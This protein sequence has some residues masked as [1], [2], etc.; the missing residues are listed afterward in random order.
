[1]RIDNYLVFINK[2]SSR[3]KAKEAVERGEVFVNGKT[4]KPSFEVCDD[5]NIT[6]LDKAG[7]FVSN[8]A[9]KLE[10]AFDVFPGFNVEDKIC[11]DIGASTGGFTQSLLL[12][13]AKRVFAVDV[14]QSLLNEALAND[15]RVIV[16]DNTNARYIKRNDFCDCIDRIV[17]DVSFIS[18]T[19]IL[20]SAYSVLS[21]GGEAVLL[22]KPQFECGPKYL[23]KNGI[24]VDK[25][26]RCEACLKISR[27]AIDIGFGVFGFNVA[28]IKKDKNTEFLIY[29][30]KSE[31]GHVSLDDIATFVNSL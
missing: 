4:V 25:R 9:F 5:D 24:V 7:M 13:G 1:M 20:P 31:V 8:G 27:F 15:D 16:M 11:L 28:P 26:A 12:H 22:I 23:S 19:Y 6:Y 2:F 21:D 29:L 18:L 17:S 3:T 14:G 30:K 10:R